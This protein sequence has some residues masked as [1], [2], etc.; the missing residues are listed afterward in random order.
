MGIVS[1][2]AAMRNNLLSLQNTASLVTQTQSRL[3][4]G[5]RVAA[6]VDDPVAYF[7]GKSLMDRASDIG[8]RKDHINQGISTVTAAADGLQAITQVV[9]QL[10]GLAQTS[11]SAT[12]SGEIAVI[13]DQFNE[14]RRQINSLSKDSSYQGLN[15]IHGTG[16][17]LEVSF[18]NTSS[19]FL[20][21]ESINATAQGIGINAV[22]HIQDQLATTVPP[23]GILTGKVAFDYQGS[24]ASTTL[25]DGQTI[26]F[27]LAMTGNI[28]IGPNAGLI[29][30]SYGTL[31]VSVAAGGGGGPAPLP[32]AGII[33]AAL[34]DVT[35]GTSPL[36]IAG[37][38]TNRAGA[39]GNPANNTG[40][41]AIVSFNG[42]NATNL[43]IIHQAA[44]DAGFTATQADE[45]RSAARVEA[46]AVWGT[47]GPVDKLSMQV[48][49]AITTATAGAASVGSVLS[50]V[51]ST[52]YSTAM[53]QGYTAEE[54]NII[55]NAA[56]MAASHNAGALTGTLSEQIDTVIIKA[57]AGVVAGAGAVGAYRKSLEI[58]GIAGGGGGGT[59]G[60]TGMLT[61]GMV[62]Q[63]DIA[64]LAADVDP[65]GNQIKIE[66]LTDAAVPLTMRPFDGQTTLGAGMVRT[67]IDVQRQLENAVTSV[68]SASQSLG[69]NI[70]LLQ[71][72]L[73]FS[74]S[75]INTLT[76]G[77]GKLTLA[78]MNEE[79]AKMLALQ[80]RQQLGI[81]SLSMST[82][83]G[84]LQLFQ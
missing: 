10:Q 75:Y 19:S 27:T 11:R 73:D 16:Q 66:G 68:R 18:S 13:V 7:Q 42:Y 4:T 67:M 51:R 9:N 23:T 5:L 39:G 76:A 35:A 49:K 48:Y 60:L 37:A 83:R 53:A 62:L 26:S 46:D 65:T 79:S 36:G 25:L 55:A 45:I 3:S 58:S 22:R 52:T 14:L 71:I 54:A 74:I 61:D 30:F 70:A 78:D 15:L 56:Q 84:V 28:L 24:T 8:V 32:F 34:G 38:P 33:S 43:A 63:F 2:S 82:G 69:L 12:S 64:A 80:T 31:T 41:P 20:N 6:A 50:V 17:R 44:I 47:A 72:R 1:L 57:A 77:T 21:I 81:Q 59:G 40:L 29:Q